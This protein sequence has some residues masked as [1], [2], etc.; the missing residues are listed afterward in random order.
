[1]N[2]HIITIGDELLIG[3]VIDTNSAWIGEQLTELGVQ[4]D[5]ILSIRDV[6]S[7]IIKHLEASC[8]QADLVIVSGGLGP[9][10][11]DITKTS[12]AKMLGKKMAFNIDVYDAIV[13][14]LEKHGRKPVDAIKHHSYFPEGTIFLQN[15]MGTAPGM[16]FKK[17]NCTLISVP[18][19]PYEMKFIMENEGLDL[20][21]A[22]N[23][24]DHIV[25]KTIL[26]V[27]EFEARLSDRIADIVNEMPDHMS[28]AFLPNLNQVRLRLT[29]KG[30]DKDKLKREIQEISSQIEGRLGLQVFGEGKENLAQALGKLLIKNH[31]TM[32]TAESCT[33][34]YL[35][36]LITSNE[37]SSDY[38]WGSIVSYSNEL[39][40]NLLQ[41]SEA[42][43]SQH[44]AVSEETVLEM[45]KGVLETTQ[46]DVAISVS[47]IAGPGGGTPEKPVGT[48]WMACGNRHKSVT[49]KIL[50][51][52]DRIKNIQSGAIHALDLLRLFILENY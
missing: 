41:V 9:T 43:L 3:Q 47:G 28:I 29:G 30:K 6:E 49:K 36:H 16:V 7:E 51:A 14:Y 26:T 17:G 2:A 34:G 50:V 38:F 4:V 32:S 27:G 24:G 15:N 18:G 45:L 11:D 10:K 13:R 22:L 42:T 37:G 44:G 23:S 19:V 21:K 1:M 35:A 12:I 5:M 8:L 33:G 25:K 52:K 40:K 31:L 20:I 48:I 46:T 39:K